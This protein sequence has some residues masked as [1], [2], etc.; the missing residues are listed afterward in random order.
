MPKN[1][2]FDLKS[3]QAP[4]DFLKFFTG[5]RKVEDFGKMSANMAK[6]KKQ[7]ESQAQR[8]AQASKYMSR[9]YKQFVS[10]FKN[11]LAELM[12]TI[13]DVDF[14]ASSLESIA[15]SMDDLA[16]QGEN[17]ARA[18]KEE[19]AALHNM[20]GAWAKAIAKHEKTQDKKD[21]MA[22]EIAFKA[23]GKALNNSLKRLNEGGFFTKQSQEDYK[24]MANVEATAFFASSARIVK[25]LEGFKKSLL[26]NESM[27][28]EERTFLK[29]QESNLSRIFK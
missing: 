20:Y 10:S 19:S 1:D 7:V 24:K 5:S 12:G 8:V 17:S 15:R 27:L 16:K 29:N 11:Q 2:A 28:K 25:A 26:D 9:E 18:L 3:Q 14:A 22:V 21:A 4:G 13:S 6:T 23:Y